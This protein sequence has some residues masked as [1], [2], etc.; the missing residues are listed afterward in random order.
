[1]PLIKN[2]RK[3]ATFL[4]RKRIPLFEVLNKNV[5]YK[6]VL[7]DKFR[8]AK[9]FE[10]R[11]HLY[12][13]LNRE[14]LANEPIQYLEF[15]V[16]EGATLKKWCELNSN[17]QSSFYG[18]DTFEGLPEDWNANHPKGA[19]H[20]QGKMPEIG[21]ARAR[22]VKGLFQ[23]SL[24]G[25]LKT[26]RNDRRLVVHIDSDLYS[27]ALYCLA[28]LND[29][30]APGSL[31]LFDEF[32]ELEDEFSAFWDYTRAFYRQWEGLGFATF[33]THVA[34]MVKE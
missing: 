20:V 33:Y 1:M 32:R 24:P 4:Y 6:Q 21:D 13:Y 5:L 12:E 29:F 2:P 15:G 9:E 19:F 3:W 16:W 7:D 27:S 10:S 11:F 23:E 31:V 14:I 18:F 22:C 34:F 30:L 17:P 28:K 25:F 26:F 8:N